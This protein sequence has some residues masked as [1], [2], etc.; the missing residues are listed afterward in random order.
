MSGKNLSEKMRD[1][2]NARAVEDA[3][4]YAAFERMGQDDEEFFATAADL[5]RRLESELKRLPTGE[6]RARRALEIGC[7]PGRLMRPMSSNFGEIHGVDVSGEMIRLA[8][9]KL[10]SVPNAHPRTTNGTDLSCYAG[11]SFDY[12]YSYAVF[13]H[14]PDAQMVFSY[15]SEARRVLKRDGILHCQFNGL[16]K[17]GKQSTTWDGVRIGAG[18]IAEFACAHDFQLLAIEGADTQYMWAT[19]RKRPPGWFAGLAANPPQAVARILN[20]ENLHTGNPVISASGRLA[21]MTLLMEAPA[22]RIAI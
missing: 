22:G 19:M 18:E 7:G 14:I 3:Y 16:P 4:Y 8:E 12:V 13:Q 5:V 11:E 15:L 2:W 1:D 21:C 9:E 10:E 17:N 20:I 6:P